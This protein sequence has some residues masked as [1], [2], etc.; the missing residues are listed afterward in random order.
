MGPL[1]YIF[2]KI[3]IVFFHVKNKHEYLISYNFVTFLELKENPLDL[4]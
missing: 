4:F 1:Y 3:I 2:F